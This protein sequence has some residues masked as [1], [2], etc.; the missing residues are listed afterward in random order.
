[1]KQPTVAATNYVD[2]TL[3]LDF[4]IRKMPGVQVQSG[5]LVGGDVQTRE[6]QE[7]VIRNFNK[8]KGGLD[9]LIT[10]YKAGGHG[11]DLPRGEA[12][13]YAGLPVSVEMYMQMRG[14]VTRSR[15][16][17]EPKYLNEYL[18]FYAGTLEADA[19]RALVDVRFEDLP[20]REV[21]IIGLPPHLEVV[22][23]Q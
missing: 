17:G 13:I 19:V 5:Y 10:D 20:G 7:E 2:S 12:V 23:A 8:P 22:Y 14:R 4:L 6:Q 3:E 16:F 18:P 15:V 9:L 11:L 21:G 1:M